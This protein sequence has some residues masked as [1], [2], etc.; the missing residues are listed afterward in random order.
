M[1]ILI[2]AGP[3]WERVD[4]VRYIGNR[5]SGK[6]GIAL[7]TA[8]YLR[9]ADVCYISTMP[10]DDLPGDLYTI[11]VEDAT[12]MHE[13]IVD[14]IRVA[15]KGVLK[16]AS[17]NDTEPMG[18]I[19]KTPYLFMAAA[20]ADFRPRY[21]QE[22]K[23]K[24]D[25]VGEAWSLELARTDDILASLDKSGI[26]TVGFKAEMDPDQGV[27]NAFK[28]L[29][30]KGIDAVC[31]N[32]IDANQGFGSEQNRVIFMTPDTESDLGTHSKQALAFKILDESSKLDETA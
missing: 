31:Y 29:E 10:H 6:M 27:S 13:Y 1:R 16:K 3:T 7:A 15:K 14:S 17:M 11:D 21:P 8:L 25:Q 30:R 20:V 26:V 19:Q 5:S 9:G 22:G 4:A 12:E 24:K 32:H 28:S 2:T 23:L 18:W